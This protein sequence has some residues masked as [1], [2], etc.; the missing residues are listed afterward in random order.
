MNWS[1]LIFAVY[2]PENVT[3]GASSDIKRATRTAQNMIQKWGFSEKVGPVFYNDQ[4]ETISPRR[5]E[6]IEEEV[7]K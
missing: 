3:S 4:D 7:R 5:R 6:E 2:G 1:L